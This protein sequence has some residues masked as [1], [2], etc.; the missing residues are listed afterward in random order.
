MLPRSKRIASRFL[1]HSVD[2]LGRTDMRKDSSAPSKRKQFTSMTIK[3]SPRREIASDIYHTGVSSETPA[4][5]VRVSDSYGVSTPKLILTS[6][7]CG[8]NKRMHFSETYIAG[9]MEWYSNHIPY[10]LVRPHIRFFVE[11][12]SPEFPVAVHPHT[13]QK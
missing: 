2:A 3:A 1:S 12:Q 8:L 10:T 4:F 11:I 6:R 9:L 7:N 13:L 5:G